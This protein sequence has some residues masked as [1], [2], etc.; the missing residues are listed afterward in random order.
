MYQQTGSNENA[1]KAT[2]LKGKNNNLLVQQT[3][4]RMKGIPDSSYRI[5]PRLLSLDS[6]FFVIGTLESEFQKQNPDS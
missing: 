4:R 2:R 5:P 6:T 3:F 1:E